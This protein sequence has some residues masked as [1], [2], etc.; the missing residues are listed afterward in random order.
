MAIYSKSTQYAIRALIQLARAGEGEFV[1]TAD[2]AGTSDVPPPFLSKIVQALT[3]AGLVQS[4]RGR[5]GGICLTRSPA[6]IAL[7]DIVAAVD[8]KDLT[9]ECALGLSI[10]SDIA[11]CPIHD[12]WKK[13]RESLLLE[14][15]E[16]TLDALSSTLTAKQQLL[17]QRRNGNRARARVKN[18]SGRMPKRR[19]TGRRNAE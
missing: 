5:G 1:R 12:A 17:K 18:T 15:H 4:L 14:L 19:T 6:T 10:C 16:Q 11:P 7:D 2:V 3:R 8:G 9:R 13:V